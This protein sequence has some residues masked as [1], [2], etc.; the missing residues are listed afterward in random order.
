MGETGGS[1]TCNKHPL[2]AGRQRGTYTVLPSTLHISSGGLG[3][4]SLLSD[5][6][7]I[8]SICGKHKFALSKTATSVNPEILGV[9]RVSCNGHKRTTPKQILHKGC[10]RPANL[11]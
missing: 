11:T 2:A 9:V 6:Q 3:Q 7:V 1:I 4:L 5:Q 8:R 10:V